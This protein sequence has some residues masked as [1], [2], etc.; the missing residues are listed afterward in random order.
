MHYVYISQSKKKE[1]EIYKGSTSDL[2]A[3][4]SEHNRGNVSYTA[5]LRPWRIIFYCAFQDKKRALEFEKYLKPASGIAF[6]RRRL[7]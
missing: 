5:K 3:R 1:D 7:I 6:V 4:L 2:K